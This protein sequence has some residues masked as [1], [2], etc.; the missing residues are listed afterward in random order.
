MHSLYFS[1]GLQLPNLTNS[2]KQAYLANISI[3]FSG[4]LHHLPLF[5]LCSAAEVLQTHWQQLF[6]SCP[7]SSESH[8]ESF[9]WKFSPWTVRQRVPPVEDSAAKC[10]VTAQCF[11]SQSSQSWPS[12]RKVSLSGAVERGLCSSQLLDFTYKHQL[13]VTIKFNLK[14]WT[15]CSVT[16]ILISSSHQRRRVFRR[17]QIQQFVQNFALLHEDIRLVNLPLRSYLTVLYVNGS[18]T[19]HILSR[20]LL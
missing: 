9:N 18:F 17:C 6:G 16:L 7:Q 2:T 11:W 13:R 14:T 15:Q 1:R 3:K 4:C 8:Q 5:I 20:S 19:L 10:R 12:A